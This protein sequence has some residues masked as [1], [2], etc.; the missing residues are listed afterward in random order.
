MHSAVSTQRLLSDFLALLWSE[1]LQRGSFPVPLL[2]RGS[3]L[4]FTGLF[5]SPPAVGGC[6]RCM[7]HTQ[8]G[9]L[10]GWLWLSRGCSVPKSWT[11]PPSVSPPTAPWQSL[12]GGSL[13]VPAAAGHHG[14]PHP[15]LSS[16][17]LQESPSGPQACKLRLS[18]LA[19]DDGYI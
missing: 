14:G 7:G 17:H 12:L 2:P 3:A 10:A 11:G 8:R 13:L 16:L 5:L 4:F 6:Q 9:R 15:R 1:W 18:P 19:P